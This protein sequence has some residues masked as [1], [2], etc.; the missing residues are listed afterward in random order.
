[1]E[2]LYSRFEEDKDEYDYHIELSFVEIYN[3]MIIDLLVDEAPKTEGQKT[4]GGGLRLLENEK[5]RVSI[6]GVTL[7]RPKS[8]D[9]VMEHVR[10]GNEKR[11]TQSTN[12]NAE[13]SRSHA[14]L[15][16]NIGR[17]SRGTQ[18]D[19][20]KQVVRQCVTS[21]TLSI[22]DLAGSERAAATAALKNNNERQK[23]GAKINTSLLS[24]SSCISALCQKPTR[25]AVVHVPYRNSKLTRL[26][27]FS[28]G[29][30][31]R[32]V[33]VVCISPSSKDIEDTH[34]TLTWANRAKEVTTKISKNTQGV[35]V[36]IQQ[37]LQ[38]I[39]EQE[40]RIEELEKERVA[41]PK[42]PE[43]AAVLLRRERDRHEARQ[44]LDG[45][46]AEVELSQ[47]IINE[48]AEK[49]A[50]WDVSQLTVTALL[51]R[52]QDLQTEIN[53]RG[54]AIVARDVKYLRSRIEDEQSKYQKNTLVHKIVQREVNKTKTI[55]KHV[56]NVSNQSFDDLPEAE[57]ERLKL[58]L[59]HKRMSVD[60]QVY[61]AR[62]KGY[63]AMHRH[64]A[65]MQAI[66]HQ[67]INSVKDSMDA[68]A[69]EMM[70]AGGTATTF[71]L[72]LR[73]MVAESDT[74]LSTV[75]GYLSPITDALPPPVSFKDVEAFNLPPTPAPQRSRMSLA[76]PMA[77]ADP[78]S[79]IKP[80]SSSS[81]LLQ[82]PAPPSLLPNAGGPSSLSLPPVNNAVARLRGVPSGPSSPRRK[83]PGSPA[84]L[85]HIIKRSALK[86]PP[87]SSALKPASNT[88]PFR[89]GTSKTFRFKS[90]NS[91]N[92][93]KIM[94]DAPTDTSPEN[95]PG[96]DSTSSAG[97]WQDEEEEVMVKV[98]TPLRPKAKLGMPSR[99]LAM[100]PLGTAPAAPIPRLSLAPL[101][102]SSVA[103][104][105]E[106]D[107]RAARARTLNL[108]SESDEEAGFASSTQSAG[109]TSKSGLGS[110]GPP[111]SRPARSS[112][113]AESRMNP[114]AATSRLQMP[115]AASAAKSNGELSVSL[116][117]IRD[118]PRRESV[119]HQSRMRRTS[120]I[121]Q[122][123]RPS[124]PHSKSDADSADSLLPSF[125]RPTQS[126]SASL[127]LGPARRRDSMMPAPSS[128]LA[129]PPIMATSGARTSISASSSINGARG[130]IGLKSR[131]SV[132]E[133]GVN[134]GSG[135][136][137]SL[138]SRQSISNLREPVGGGSK[139][140][141]K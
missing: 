76:F 112:P 4:G 16:I 130:V 111:P 52:I 19:L 96:N 136:G 56:E 129:R 38:R 11:A 69:S 89:A 135:L 104:G 93:E 44:A 26:L 100:R 22:I 24:L 8:V 140:Q 83:A 74:V 33:M 141:W 124:L 122:Y 30:N 47:P 40:R 99:S 94:S 10:R 91:I 139:A 49:R 84:K 118:P 50:L 25:G 63:R 107:W 27:K 28:L 90:D 7:K 64:H 35:D 138:A 102:A 78:L 70:M 53:T 126:S 75:H 46:D 133:F 15:Q 137:T 14:V 73:A 113:L 43:N 54:A 77:S 37:Y 117:S 32:T 2:Y 128:S 95:S 13:S 3:E 121:S 81:H 120:H 12:A 20:Q 109:N 71:A 60:M 1:M 79:P 68:L 6:A 131:A 88:D 103:S 65:N 105:S 55:E 39:A 98:A 108:V 41:G 72:R 61:V 57:K 18:V 85:K 87:K 17:V 106:N 51:Q 114:P 97:E 123:Q 132:A 34:N 36:R 42:V 134:P 86:Q 92:E 67:H 59:D 29:G 31:C 66:T 62:E 125:M 119:A 110:T 48:G 80:I 127:G 82:P 45:L 115:T 21:A 101:A 9:E 116:T 23:E 58:Q 5:N